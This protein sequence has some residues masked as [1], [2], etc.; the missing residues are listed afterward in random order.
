MKRKRNKYSFCI[1]FTLL[2]KYNNLIY[3]NL[4]EATFYVYICIVEKKSK[5]TDNVLTFLLYCLIIIFGVNLE[6]FV[7]RKENLCFL[8]LVLAILDDNH[9]AVNKGLS[10][11]SLNKCR[12]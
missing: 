4:S 3:N 12:V 6:N 10:G 5:K 2:E 8:Q 7:S 11:S 1:F 9:T